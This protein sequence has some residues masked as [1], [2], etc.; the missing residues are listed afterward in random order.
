MRETNVKFNVMGGTK[1]VDGRAPRNRSNTPFGRR[2]RLRKERSVKVEK[3]NGWGARAI[4]VAL[5]QKS[6]TAM[7]A[8]RPGDCKYQR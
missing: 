8:P 2:G 5:N 3:E 6:T 4:V 7:P 1:L